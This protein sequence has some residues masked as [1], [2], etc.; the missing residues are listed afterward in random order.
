MQKLLEELFKDII[1]EKLFTKNVI[2]WIDSNW[3]SY[4]SISKNSPIAYSF[5]L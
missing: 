1:E 3:N 5:I 4:E 2:H